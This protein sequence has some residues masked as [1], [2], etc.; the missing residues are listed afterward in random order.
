MITHISTGQSPAELR[1]RSSHAHKSYLYLIVIVIIVTVIVIVF[2]IVTVIVITRVTLHFMGEETLCQTSE[3]TG[4]DERCFTLV[5]FRLQKKLFYRV[6]FC[7]WASPKKLKY[8][9]PRLGE[10]TLTRLS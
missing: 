8:A 7:H 3:K 2:V 6:F 10:S 9:K 4:R 5:I 1:L